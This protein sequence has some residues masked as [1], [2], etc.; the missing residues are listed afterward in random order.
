MPTVGITAGDNRF[1][2][3]ARVSRIPRKVIKAEIGRG[4][5]NLI[6]RL[7]DRLQ[8]KPL[9][10]IRRRKRVP[11]FVHRL[12]TVDEMIGNVSVRTG[13]QVPTVVRK[14]GFDIAE[15]QLVAGVF[16]AL[17]QA[18]GIRVLAA[19]VTGKHRPV[20]RAT[21]VEIEIGARGIYIHRPHRCDP[22]NELERK[23]VPPQVNHGAIKHLPEHQAVGPVDQIA[24]RLK[25][26]IDR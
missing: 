19:E 21:S 25:G 15:I 17:N 1:K 4:G 24:P 9:H 3:H 16:V 26:D 13:T 7:L 22:G 11:P 18:I 2:P 12:H 14:M 6:P 8:A 5:L 23:L 20:K 10:K